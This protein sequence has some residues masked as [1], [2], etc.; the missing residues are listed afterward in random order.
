MSK[1]NACFPWYACQ[2]RPDD[3]DFLARDLEI[4][5]AVTRSLFRGGKNTGA[6][7]HS[8]VFQPDTLLAMMTEE[9][10]I[11]I[12]TQTADIRQQDTRAN[13]SNTRVSSGS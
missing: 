2:L 11:Y 4:R 12:A 13:L 6:E 3:D 1:N 8:K 5:E 7:R 10:A 9:S